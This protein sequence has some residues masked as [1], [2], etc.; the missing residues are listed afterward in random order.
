MNGYVCACIQYSK[1]KDMHKMQHFWLTNNAESWPKG[2]KE[3]KK[4]KKNLR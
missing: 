4:C 2:L 1:R 3:V